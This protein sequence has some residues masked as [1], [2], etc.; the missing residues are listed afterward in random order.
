[1]PS[2]EPSN[3]TNPP[4]DDGVEN[5]NYNSGAFTDG[6]TMNHDASGPDRNLISGDQADHTEQIDMP[7]VREFTQNDKI[8]KFLLNSF[9]QRINDGLSCGEDNASNET[10]AITEEQEQDFES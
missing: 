5:S 10:A 9:L 7:T 2:V 3:E 8:N 4:R 6:I 1:M